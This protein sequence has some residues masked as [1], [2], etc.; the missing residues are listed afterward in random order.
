[1]CNVTFSLTRRTHLLFGALISVWILAW[2]L[3]VR[4]DPVSAWLAGSE[5]SFLYWTTAKVLIWILP[6]LYLVKLSGRTVREVCGLSMWQ[7]WLA[8][9]GGIG[10]VMALTGFIPRY[11][12]GRPLLPTPDFALLNVLVIAPVFEEFLMRGAI[13]G[14]LKKEASVLKANLVSSGMFV[15]LHLPGWFFTGRLLNNLIQP[16]GGAL[17]I[18]VVGL[19]CGYATHRSRSVVAGMVAHCLNNLGS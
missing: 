18:F 19:L 2:I 3:K 17:S 13:F 8:W 1:M 6:A 11:F 14:A 4:L 15:A 10:G 7:R 16:V 9:G 5:G 12:S